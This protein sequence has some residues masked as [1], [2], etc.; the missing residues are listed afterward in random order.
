MSHLMR[1]KAPKKWPIGRKGSAY[2][3]RP[4]SSLDQGV[5]LLIVL[6]DLLKLAQNRKEVKKIIHLKQILV[7]ERPAR[8]EKEN[9]LFFDTISI[10]PMKKSYRMEISGSGKFCLK[11]IKENEANK[12][13]SKV[14]NKKVL[15]RKKVQINLNDGRN[16][17]SDLKCEIND[18]VIINVKDRKIEKSIPLKEKS[19]I[20]VFAGKHL[21][22]EGEIVSLDT[23]EKT[24]KINVEGK[25]INILI[26]QI[27]AIENDK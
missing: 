24:A 12:K 14:V 22:K 3:V 16:F 23:K 18:S 4:S 6:R 1:Q 19:K 2:I 20:V 11:E 13:I 5:P 9:I 17:L 7:N 8:D 27:M 10:V 26:K 15:K 25:E 21:G